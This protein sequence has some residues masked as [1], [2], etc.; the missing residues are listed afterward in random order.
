MVET[1]GVEMAG[2]MYERKPRSKSVTE[3]G[4]SKKTLKREGDSQQDASLPRPK[5]KSTGPTQTVIFSPCPF[6]SYSIPSTFL[7]LLTHS[8]LRSTHS[9]DAPRPDQLSQMACREL[10]QAQAACRQLLSV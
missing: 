2:Q 7:F 1:R 4:Q 6:D 10:A 9:D 3:R 8:R 5:E